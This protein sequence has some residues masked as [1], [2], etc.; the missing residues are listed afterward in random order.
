MCSKQFKIFG[1][2][3]YIAI[4][5]GKAGVVLAEADMQTVPPANLKAL[6]AEAEAMRNAGNLNGAQLKLNLAL[7]LA[8]SQTSFLPADLAAVEM[9]S[10]YN[11][12]LLDH[13]EAAAQQLLAA[14]NKTANAEPYLHALAAEYLAYLYLSNA[15]QKTAGEYVLQALNSLKSSEY[16]A[17]RLSLELLRL[18]LSE[19]EDAEKSTVVADIAKRVEALPADF[20]R[21]KL[22]LAVS[23]S[24]VLLDQNAIEPNNV[25]GLGESCRQMLENILSLTAQSG[26]E[27]F[28]AEAL[29][30]QIRLYRWLQ[31]NDLALALTDS[32]LRL[33]YQTQAREL[34]AQLL[35]QQADLLNLQGDKVRA[36]Q[37]YEQ[38]VFELNAIRADLPITL[39]DGRA[40][41]N[42]LTDPIHRGYVDLLLQSV[43]DKQP[44]VVQQAIIDAV[45]NME[46]VKAADMQDFFLG[47]CDTHTAKPLDWKTTPLLDAAIVYPIILPDRLSIII[48]TDKGSSLHT[49]KVAAGKVK[50]LIQKL[51][52]DVQ[53]GLPFRPAA[54][55]LYDWLVRPVSEE[56]RQAQIKT[57]VYVPD[58]EMRT[59]PIAL[60]NDGKHFLAE[61]FAVVTMPNL[62]FQ[63]LVRSS[64]DKKHIRQLFAGLSTPDGPS[65]DKIPDRVLA[66]IGNVKSPEMGLDAKGGLSNELSLPNVGKEI[67]AL[68]KDQNSQV[69][70][71]DK[72][73]LASFKSNLESGE[74]D[75]VHIASHGFFGNNAKDSFILAYDEI[76]SLENF[77][78]SLEADKLKRQPIKMLTLSACETAQGNDRMLLGFSGMAIKSNVESALGSL[79]TIDDEG[80]MEFMKLF[81]AGLNQSMQKAQAVQHAQVEMINSRKYKHPYYWSA[82]ILTG[83]WK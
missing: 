3:A 64:D 74:Y 70:L 32:A 66:E 6:V 82:F 11:L 55:Q 13:K 45:D 53:S 52:A 48:K 51:A 34:A 79:W 68:A 83:N 21:A 10:G 17:L 80:T 76:L 77:Q 30:T 65:I 40:V 67:D 57:L 14:Y 2:V 7:E 42:V 12:F 37:A 31:K 15:E 8:K 19:A 73:T 36:L 1:L 22:E 43:E 54:K 18:N 75:K 39:P 50:E 56:L 4:S 81:Y 58:R 47:K 29:A 27:R 71:N 69:L 16:P 5:L 72:F 63:P 62:V 26:Q 61:T 23:Q 20:I 46:I 41:L 24:I 28:R 9:A 59:L 33:A 35:A 78:G 60:F 44:E 25:I 49:V 38:A